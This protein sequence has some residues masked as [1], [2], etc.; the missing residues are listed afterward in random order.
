MN[1]TDGFLIMAVLDYLRENNIYSSC[2]NPVEIASQLGE[3]LVEMIDNVKQPE[4]DV[5]IEEQLGLE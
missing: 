1:R 5:D 3:V 4:D 2:I